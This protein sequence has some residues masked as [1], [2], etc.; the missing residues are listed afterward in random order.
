MDAPTTPRLTTHGYVLVDVSVKPPV[1]AE[2]FDIKRSRQE[3]KTLL[4][5][6]ADA[7]N[8]RVRRARITVYES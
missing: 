3:A 2:P 7:D 4:Q 1:L 8:L 6:R 5:W